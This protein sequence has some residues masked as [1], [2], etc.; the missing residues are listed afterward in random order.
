MTATQ[1]KLVPG[2]RLTVEEHEALLNKMTPQE[3][4]IHEW[5]QQFETDYRDKL[6]HNISVT[7]SVIKAING[8]DVRQLAHDLEHAIRL[9]VWEDLPTGLAQE[10]HRKVEH[11]TFLQ[12]CEQVLFT[13]PDELMR[14]MSGH[15]PDANTAGEAAIAVIDQV[16]SEEPD[17]LKVL[18]HQAPGT[19][20]PGWRQ[21]VDSKAKECNG[22]WSEC[23]AYLSDVMLGRWVPLLVTR[24]GKGEIM[25]RRTPH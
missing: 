12:W 4:A 13:S 10:R 5:Y 1:T 14:I 9:R 16:S 2:T 19:N 21:L 22:K 3:R 8:C 6:K 18:T 24:T 20:L 7:S 17:M 11:F 25:Q 15:L 23:A